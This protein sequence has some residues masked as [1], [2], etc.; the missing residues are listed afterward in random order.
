MK[1][2]RKK[3]K[4]ELENPFVKKYKFNSKILAC[5]SNEKKNEIYCQHQNIIIDL[6]NDDCLAAIFMY[7]PACERPKIALVCQKWK[8]A[9]YYSW[10]NVKKLELTHWEYDEYPTCL[11]KY[12]TCLKKYLIN[13]DVIV[14]IIMN[15]QFFTLTM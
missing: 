15:C 8:R 5:Y 6:V 9:L 12:P 10:S 7:V 4:S 1:E 3:R 14:S 11:K 2:F 13:F